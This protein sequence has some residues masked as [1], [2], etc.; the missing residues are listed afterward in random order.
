[1]SSFPEIVLGIRF[2]WQQFIKYMVRTV[3]NFTKQTF[4]SIVNIEYPHKPYIARN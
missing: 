2:R 1:V 4:I 3:P